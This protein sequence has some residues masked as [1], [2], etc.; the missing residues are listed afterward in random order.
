MLSL[1]LLI[2]YLF[3]H[4][5]ASEVKMDFHLEVDQEYPEH[6]EE[7]KESLENL[8]LRQPSDVHVH[9]RAHVFLFHRPKV[10]KVN[11]D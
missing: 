10:H 6:L 8:Q 5:H 9:V 2:V 7:Q 3:G 11:L 1:A 4:D